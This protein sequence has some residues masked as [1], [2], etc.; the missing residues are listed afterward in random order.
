MPYTYHKVTLENG[1]TIILQNLTTVPFRLSLTGRAITGIEV[2]RNGDEISHAG[3]DER[4]H[5]ISEDAV[6]SVREM[7]FSN[8]YGTLEVIPKRK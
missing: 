1:K 4:K 5:I 6:K 7:R 8:R 3:F 2:N